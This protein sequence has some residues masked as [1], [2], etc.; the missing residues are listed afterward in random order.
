MKYCA[1]RSD[2]MR[3][4]WRA[5]RQERREAAA[6]SVAPANRELKNPVNPVKFRIPLYEPSSRARPAA[7]NGETKIKAEIDN[8]LIFKDEFCQSISL[9]VSVQK[10][11]DSGSHS[12]RYQPR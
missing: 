2:S 1:T 8:I 3:L 6:P 12:A 9:R 10:A 11:L 5:V 7:P 4:G